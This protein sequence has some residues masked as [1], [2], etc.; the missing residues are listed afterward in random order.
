ME[1]EEDA[2]TLDLIPLNM[3]ETLKSW[4]CISNYT[5]AITLPHYGAQRD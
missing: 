3:V 1:A 4:A 5:V 2:L